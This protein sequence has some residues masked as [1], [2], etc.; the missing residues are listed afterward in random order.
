M[1]VV[2]S[3]VW[4]ELDFEIIWLLMFGCQ[5][6]WV[7]WRRWRPLWANYR[8]YYII[9]EGHWQKRLVDGLLVVV[10]DVWK[11]LDFGLPWSLT[12]LFESQRIRVGLLWPRPLWDHI[13][14]AYIIR[15]GH[16]QKR[17]VDGLLVAVSH[18]WKKLDF[19]FPWWL[20]VLFESQRIRVGLLRPRPLWDRRR[21]YYI[22]LEEHWQK[23]SSS[24]W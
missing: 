14:R 4:K 9:L 15:K 8:R 6:L 13:R 3:H 21:Q 16:W 23:R 12:V 1:L 10:S 18:V 7:E 20:T 2:A 11:E 19:G 22:I 5:R 24:Y 17:L